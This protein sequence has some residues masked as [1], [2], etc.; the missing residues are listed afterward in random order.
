MSFITKNNGQFEYFDTQLRRPTWRGKKVFDFGGNI[1]NVLHHPDST[2]D[3]DKYWCVDVSRDAIEAGKKAAPEAHFVFYDRYNPEYNPSGIRGLPIPDI[4]DSFDFILSLSVFTH[5][6]KTEMIETVNHLRSFL[7]DSGR[8]ALTFLDP[9]YVPPGSD[10][11]NV[12]HYLEQRWNVKS[13]QYID[14]FMNKA[15]RANWCVLTGG[16]LEI[17]GDGFNYSDTSQSEDYLV[18]YTPQ[19]F[20]TIF[21][22]S[23]VL[24]PVSPFDRQHCAI[25]KRGS[26]G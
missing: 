22:E 3:H 26:C 24:A 19:Y 13:L 2:I 11:T 4:G 10:V 25:F 23:E 9:H 1:G 5:T 15:D 7:N 14:T 17:Q 6:N 20:E 16:K 18:F 21:P 12:K 8:L